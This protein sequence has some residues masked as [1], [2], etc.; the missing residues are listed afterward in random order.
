MSN[1]QQSS[2]AVESEITIDLRQFF[3]VLKKWGKLIILMT[4]LCGLATALLS[5]FVIPPTYQAQTLLI[6]TEATEKVQALNNRQ[7]EDLDKV[8]G[9][10]SRIPVLTMSTYVGQLKSETLYNRVIKRL[11]LQ[12]EEYTAASLGEMIETNVVKDSNLINVSVNNTDKVL[13]YRIANTLSDEY[14]KLMTEKNQEQMSRS[15]TFLE[16]QKKITDIELAKAEE[17]LKDFQSQ[18][19]G[20][21]ILEAEFT[22]M[23]EDKVNA[24]S[25]L[26]NAQV[27]IQQLYPGINELSQELLN[28]PKTIEVGKYNEY[29]GNSTQSQEINPL[30]VSLSQQLVEK[31]AS[32]SEKQS[33]VEALSYQIAELNAELDATQADLAVK[34]LTQDKLLME[35][36]RLRKTA[37][38]LA[39]KM[40]ETR[41][42]K[43]IDLGDTSVVVVSEAS[44]PIEPIKPNKELNIA[45][46]LILGLIIFTLLAFV[47]ERLDYT[48]KTPEDLSRELEMPVLGVIPQMNESNT[49]Q[50]S[51]GG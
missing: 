18:P 13:A 39:Q 42:A 41:I 21:A 2:K 38:T 28:I 47:L 51:Y 36:D 35:V 3:I 5:Y 10:I 15:V 50:H 16:N 48:L 19:R 34:K 29:T 17:E 37:D 27:V 7:G 8:V 11:Q 30:Y 22:K 31:R 14:L 25:Q 23:S 6:V 43:S 46:A 49:Q 45:I 4:L 20:V 26:K 44:I 24:S 1:P 32:L 9:T 33:E 40:T 12:P